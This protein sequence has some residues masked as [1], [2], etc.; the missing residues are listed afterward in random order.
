MNI[1]FILAM[2][3]FKLIVPFE[4]NDRVQ[5]LQKAWI[6]N[7]SNALGALLSNQFTLGENDKRTSLS[8]IEQIIEQSTTL[9]DI[10][11]LKHDNDII[12]VNYHFSNGTEQKSSIKLD[13]NNYILSIEYF[14]NAM[15]QNIASSDAVPLSDI[16]FLSD[17]E[18]LNLYQL[19]INEINHYDAEARATRNNSKTVQ[20]SE[21]VEHHKT[22]FI[23]SQSWQ[24]LAEN[25]QAF[26]D[27]FVNLH[28]HMSF[29]QEFDGPTKQSQISIGYTYP[30][31][32]F[33]IN[34]K[35]KE[36][37][38]KINDLAIEHVFDHYENYSC[39]HNSTIGC[40]D[41]FSKDF[42]S[43]TLK[44]ENQAVKQI[45]TATQSIVLNYTDK[46]SIDPMQK[47]LTPIDVNHYKNW[48]IVNKGYKTAI[49]KKDND[50]LIVI[51]NFVYP[52]GTGGGLRCEQQ[53][54]EKTMCHDIQMIRKALNHF[55]TT[56]YNLIIDVQNNG[57]G[58]ENSP[59][60]AELSHKPFKDLGVQYRNTAL[61]HDKKMRQYLFYGSKRA[62]SWF[63]DLIKDT[64]RF[65]QQAF[66]PTRSDFCRGDEKCAIKAMEPNGSRNFKN[67][68]ILTNHNC[69][70]SCDDFVWRMQE[71]SGAKVFGLPN[72][73]DATYSRVSI[74]FYIDKNRKLST[75][76]FGDGGTAQ[77]DGTELFSITIPY[78]RTVDDQGQLRQGIAAQIDQI[79]PIT[80]HNFNTHDMEVLSQASQSLN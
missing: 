47:Y 19:L 57:G 63:S 28:S 30:D 56:Q 51:K 3:L 38:V 5:A 7:D 52:N 35:D 10:T 23:N 39:A 1:F 78:S 20:W 29:N 25:F 32:S 80:K 24:E 72:A 64:N 55:D 70:S 74:T 40:M 31:M 69:V 15:S 53:A 60:L 76:Y 77:F 43:G 71:Y 42:E 14:E 36:N 44:I 67:V 58:N 8:I 34:D 62:E 41:S 54:N 46:E 18:R 16:D 50:L 65:N 4:A 26:A 68:V 75:A 48:K 9:T 66:L 21:Y 6:N 17:H 13:E 2:L 33:F 61:L 11:M 12:E 79:I 59:F 73:A 22:S 45:T 37:I 49:L 27:G